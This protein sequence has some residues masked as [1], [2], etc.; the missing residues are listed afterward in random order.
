MV[1]YKLEHLTQSDDQMV[2]GPVQDDEALVLFSIIKCMLIKTVLELGGLS[3]YSAKN[4]L[5]AVGETGTVFTVDL[6]EIPPLS[7]NHITIQ[8]DT[9]LLSAE[10][11]GGKKIDL[12]F[13]DCHVYDAQW[14]MFQN[15]LK[16]GSVDDQTVLAFHDTN[17]HP[18]QQ[19]DFAYPVEDGWV[20]QSVERRMVNDFKRLGYD[21]FCFHPRQDAYDG[22]IKLRHGLTIARRFKCLVC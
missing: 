16:D 3:G 9:K 7:S 18:F 5:N 2:S 19:V 10:H 13:F 22:I 17:T 12:V 14:I 8:S 1:A 15:L 6:N 11:F 4:F 20:H 21:V